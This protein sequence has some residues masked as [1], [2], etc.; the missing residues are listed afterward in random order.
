[1]DP[2]R[3]RRMKGAR[4]LASAALDVAGALVVVLDRRGR[5]VRFNHACERT[6]GRRFEEVAG[7]PVWD[8][9]LI[10][11]E[12]GAVKQV[13]E[14]LLAHDFPNQHENHWVGKDGT[15]RLIAWSN[16]AL[17]GRRGEVRLVVGTGVDVTETRRA[18]AELRRHASR[19]QA[20]ADAA[21]VFSSGLDYLSTLDTVVTRLAETVGDSCLIR[22]ISEDGQWLEPVAFRHRDS[23]RDALI[24]ALQESAPQHVSE[25]LTARVLRD[26]EALRVPVLT[27]EQVHADMKPEYWPYLDKMG[28][29][30]IVPL[31]QGARVFGHVTMLRDSGRPPYSAE[32]E[33]FLLEVAVHAAQSIENAR[34]YGLAQAAVAARN[35]FLSIASH[36]LRT[37]LTALKLALQNLGRMQDA[38][39]ADLPPRVRD[40][41]EAAKRQATR[42]EKLVSAL[43]DV[44]RIQA[45]RFE[46]SL[47][48]VDLSAVVYEA[49]AHLAEP[50]A[51]AGCDARV[52][53]EGS[54]LGRWD[55]FRVGQVVTNLISNAIKYG[56]GKPIE[57]AV[58]SDGQH[59]RLTVR[60][61]GVGLAPEEQAR[62][63]QRFA[64]APSTRQ[65]GGL[66]LGLYIV[67]RLVEAHGGAVS[68]E[69]APGRGAAF[70]VELPLRAAQEAAVSSHTG[71]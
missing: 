67:R 35:E 32:D 24:R 45:E 36:E 22:V 23:E 43:L 61:Q 9:L 37:P 44:S 10:P 14:R 31:K 70:V 55:R 28:S 62:L 39:A 64:R 59:A 11:E 19:M 46:L 69:S 34:L 8:L 49:L 48:E 4:D 26:G 60:D 16:A 12:A 58:S 17:L 3:P 33:A 47:E 20:L 29:L 5:I 66:G 42:L 53:V 63:F 25:G 15:R 56:A 71:A 1:M 40:S 65:Y 2:L 30:L 68:V 50:L 13:F 27:Q 7:R 21:R 38:G 6:T 52:R 51:E 54:V 41:I 57:V 18:E